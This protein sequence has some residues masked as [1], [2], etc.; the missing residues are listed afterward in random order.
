MKASALA[1]LPYL[2]AAIGIAASAVLRCRAAGPAYVMQSFHDDAFY[3]FTIA[4]HLAHGDGST[5]DGLTPTNGYHPLWL[6]LLTPLFRL[7]ADPMTML[8]WIKL[9]CAGCWAVSIMLVCSIARHLEAVAETSPVLLLLV[10]LRQLWLGGMETALAVTLVLVAIHQ[11]L[12]DRVVSDPTGARRWPTALLLMLAV[13][14]RLDLVFLVGA[15]CAIALSAARGAAGSER[16]R[17]AW[18]L[19][20]P[21]CV[22]LAA[23]M[24]FNAVV[25]GSAVP[26]S[27]VAK[28]LGGPFW[29]PSVFTSY[30][31]ATPIRLPGLGAPPIWC[32]WVAVVLPAMVVARAGARLWEDA[33]RGTL[34]GLGGLACALVAGN[35]FQLAYYAVN[36]SWPL[37][38]WYYYFL[39][40]L[41]V[42][43]VPILASA[44]VTRLRPPRPLVTLIPVAVALMIG[45]K[46]IAELRTPRERLRVSPSATFKTGAID[47]A[48]FLNRALPR[49]AVV[50]MGDRAGSLGYLLE[51]PLVQTEGLVGSRAYLDALS[52]GQVH[53]FLQE[54]GVA[55]VIYSGGPNS[56]SGGD[57][58]PAPEMGSDALRIREPKFGRGPKFSVLVRDRDLL[59]R[60]RFEGHGGEGGTL[61]AWRYRADLNPAVR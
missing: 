25:F 45:G 35:A 34:Q 11:A 49:D 41:L 14:A 8:L 60:Q 39:P 1:R 48:A 13:L 27:G 57:P 54:R 18:A 44:M 16:I 4:R 3:Y 40:L 24:I 29:N 43:A 2:V 47:A 20:W 37:W 26:I 38:D 61:S 30:L 52:A 51:R 59:Y 56:E 22:A 19:A 36:S 17:L 28:S 21:S 12:G 50:A 10:P 7:S 42:T 9:V 55:V 32:W 31:G 46:L 6:W 5:F 23:L 53:A 33:R 58:I 15:L